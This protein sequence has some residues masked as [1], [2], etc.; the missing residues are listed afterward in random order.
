MCK[1]RDFQAIEHRFKGDFR[2]R[3]TVIVGVLAFV[4]EA[5]RCLST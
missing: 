1:G 4:W 5:E 3:Q 2:M